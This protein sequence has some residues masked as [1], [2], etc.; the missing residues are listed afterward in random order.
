FLSGDIKTIDDLP[1]DD[2]R[3][4]IPRF[5]EPF[6]VKNIELVKAIEAMAAEKKVT[7]SQLALAWIISKGHL[8]IPGTK[9]RKYVEQNIGSARI[10]LSEAD[11]AKLESIVPLGTETGDQYDKFSMGLLDY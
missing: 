11:L 5:Q 2:F 10:N 3:R 6:F 7:S 4:A 1:A 8:P 9:R